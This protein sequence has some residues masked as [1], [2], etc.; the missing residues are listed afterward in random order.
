MAKDISGP[1]LGQKH[2]SAPSPEAPAPCP[3]FTKSF[4]SSEFLKLRRFFC[5]LF[6]NINNRLEFLKLA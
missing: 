1:D 4:S 6:E 2:Y 5:D 3:S